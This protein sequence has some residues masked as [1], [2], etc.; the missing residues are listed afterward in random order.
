MQNT[1]RSL[2]SMQMKSSLTA[3]LANI[4]ERRIERLVN[5]ALSE[6]LPPSSIGTIGARHVRDIVE[7]ARRVLSIEAFYAAQVI[8]YRGTE[9]MSSRRRERYQA[10]RL[11]AD[12]IDEDRVFSRDIEHIASFLLEKTRY[13][14]EKAVVF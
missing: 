1:A 8:E 13:R 3:E 4:S 11:I 12:P 10:I 7:N 6:E 2:K 14:V 9:T 5:P